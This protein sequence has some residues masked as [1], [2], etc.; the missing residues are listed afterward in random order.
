MEKQFGKA[1]DVAELLGISEAAAWRLAREKKFPSGCYVRLG[2][3]LL[4]F[5]LLAL[6][7]WIAE[8]GNVNDTS[9][10]QAA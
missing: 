3:R 10:V 7:K 6:R 4:R 2:R 5:D 8:G 9:E 1:S